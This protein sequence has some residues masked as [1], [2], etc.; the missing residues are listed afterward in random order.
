MCVLCGTGRH[1]CDEGF[2][3]KEDIR[4]KVSKGVSHW[5]WGHWVFGGTT[6]SG[7]FLEDHGVREDMWCSAAGLLGVWWGFGG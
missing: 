2:S 4:V 5:A 6:H 1:V 3:F 7:V